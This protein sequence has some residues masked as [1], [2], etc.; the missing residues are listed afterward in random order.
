MPYVFKVIESAGI[1]V[2]HFAYS[3]LD[4]RMADP[5]AF[6]HVFRGIQTDANGNPEIPGDWVIKESSSQD[7]FDRF[8][9]EFAVMRDLA[10]KTRDLRGIP[11]S[12]FPVYFLQRLDTE[13]PGIAM[14]LYPITIRDVIEN[15]DEQQIV[16]C[17]IDYLDMLRALHEIGYICTD[18]KVDDLRWHEESLV[19]IDWNVLRTFEEASIQAE[20]GLTVRLWYLLLTGYEPTN[21]LN[22]FNDDEWQP[23]NASREGGRIRIG[24]RLILVH[25]L[26]EHYATVDDL[27]SALVDWRTSWLASTQLDDVP[28]MVHKG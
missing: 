10:A 8:Q 26:L 7:H 13:L 20:I 9:N 27:R 4:V 1:P 11:F 15:W 12:P 25:A 17:M 16:A 5:S 28:L 3:G 24:L 2:N 18:R 21:R 14:P 19:V 22:P 6:G 23:F